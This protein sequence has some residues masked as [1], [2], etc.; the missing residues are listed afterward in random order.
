MEATF[1]TL[2]QYEATCDAIAKINAR[3]SDL[4]AR[5][6]NEIAGLVGSLKAWVNK[7]FEGY[8]TAAEVDAIVE[9]LQSQ[10]DSFSKK[11]PAKEDPR[12]DS[13]ATELTATK[14]AIETA[15]DSIRAEYKTAITD[16][17]T[18]S[19]GKMTSVINSAIAEVNSKITELTND[20]NE[21]KN[22]VNALTGRVDA[23]EKMIQSVTI[24]PEYTC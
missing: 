21:L 6:S 16:A 18:Q 9:D 4:D 13:L 5:L 11:D 24:V 17:I 1:S 7:Q 14:A 19:E 8:Y 2:E 22:W 23:L 20:V 3:I 10:I 12:I 15:K